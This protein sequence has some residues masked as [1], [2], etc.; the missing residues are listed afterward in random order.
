MAIN[1]H[2]DTVNRRIYSK[3][4]GLVTL[5]DLLKHI[6]SEVD[7]E[8][9]R[10]SEIFD[11]TGATTDLTVEQVR[12]L[13]EARRQIARSQPASPTAVVAT[14]DLFF[15]MLRMFDMLTETV[16]PMR[17]FRDLKSAEQWLDSIDSEANSESVTGEFPHPAKNPE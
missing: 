9:A 11:C 15:G 14:N 4:S 3:A 1:F 13:A 5:A 6:K 2:I 17:V 7:P 12:M 16:R 10:F 8:V